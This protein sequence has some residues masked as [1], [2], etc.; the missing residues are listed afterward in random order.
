VKVSTYSQSPRHKS[1]LVSEKLIRIATVVDTRPTEC[2]TI[3]FKAFGEI[4]VSSI[5]LQPTK[6]NDL[7]ADDEAALKKL[8]AVFHDKLVCT[9]QSNSKFDI[10]EELDAN[11]C[12]SMIDELV[13]KESSLL[14]Q[15]ILKLA[16]GN[17]DLDDNS[18]RMKRMKT[19]CYVSIEN[20][21]RATNDK[22]SKLRA[23][24]GRGA[25]QASTNI[26]QLLT[27]LGIQMDKLGLIDVMLLRTTNLNNTSR[28][29]WHNFELSILLCSCSHLP[30]SIA[31]FCIQLKNATFVIY[32]AQVQR[33]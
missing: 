23:V 22:G 32:H 18:T 8:F 4:K 30:S 7:S 12:A 17:V 14:F 11:H 5:I 6:E 15:C 33:H 13:E 1:V 25:S 28:H 29:V 21:I 2:A 26:Q 19:Q 10:D 24:M 9:E 3:D 31:L 20:I 16:M 27:K